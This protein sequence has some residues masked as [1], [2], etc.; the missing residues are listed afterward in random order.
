MQHIRFRRKC[1]VD[2]AV[3]QA[4]PAPAGRFRFARDHACKRLLFYF[5]Q[6]LL[7]PNNHPTGIQKNADG[8]SSC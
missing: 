3:K 1:P 5:H 4:S 6:K 7:L 8:L 2:I